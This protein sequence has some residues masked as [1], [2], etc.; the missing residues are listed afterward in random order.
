VANKFGIDAAKFGDFVEEEKE[1]LGA[2]SSD[3]F[4]YTEL[5]ELAEL[6]IAEGGK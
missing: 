3:D 5:L 2:G 6:Y 4:T 1:A